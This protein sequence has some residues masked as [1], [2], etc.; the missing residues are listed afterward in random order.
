MKYENALIFDDKIIYSYW[1]M[2]QIIKYALDSKNYS[3]K[4][5]SI[6]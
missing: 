1:E 5:S 3:L 2:L 6:L 4:I